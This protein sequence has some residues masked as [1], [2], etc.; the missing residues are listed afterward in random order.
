MDFA[1][2]PPGAQGTGKVFNVNRNNRGEACKIIINNLSETVN[3]SDLKQL[4]EESG[5]TRVAPT[6]ILHYDADGSAL[7]TAEASLCSRADSDYIIKEFNGTF[8]DGKQL[9][10]SIS[11]PAKGTSKRDRVRGLPFSKLNQRRDSS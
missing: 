2:R 8:V 3:S 4:F 9:R 7:G 1:L 10:M 5:R 11:I 6:P